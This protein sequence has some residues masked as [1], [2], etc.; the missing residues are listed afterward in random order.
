MPATRPWDWP[1]VN[2]E[3]ITLGTIWSNQPGVRVFVE[4]FSRG[5][6]IIFQF[7]YNR[8]QPQG[9]PSRLVNFYHKKPVATATETYVGYDEMGKVVWEVLS[10]VWNS[11]SKHMCIRMPDVMVEIFEDPDRELQ[12]YLFH[13][14]LYELYLEE[15]L[16]LHLVLTWAVAHEAI[17]TYST[18]DLI[19]HG[20]FNSQCD[21]QLVSL[22]LNPDSLFI[23]KGL[24]C[25]KRMLAGPDFRHKIKA[26]YDEIRTIRSLHPHSNIIIPHTIFVMGAEISIEPRQPLVCGTLTPYMKNG[27]LNDEI[28]R[29]VDADTRL[30]VKENAKWCFQ[31]ISAINH[32]HH[33]S[34]SYHMNIKSSNFLINDQ[35]NL[36]L[37]DWEQNKA[38]QLTLA[39]EAD[40]S[41]DVEVQ[42]QDTHVKPIYRKYPGPSR[43]N[44]PFSWP[45]WNVFPIWRHVCPR[46]LEA[47]EVYSLG[48]TM[49]MLLAQVHEELSLDYEKMNASERKFANEENYLEWSRV[50]RECMDTD[51]NKRPD[52][53]SLQDFWWKEYAKMPSKR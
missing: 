45:R 36:I 8:D 39:P 4:A 41:Y 5:L 50:V 17:W 9:I 20:Y 24:D 28:R 49:W 52:M 32:T 43:V 31:M 23:F 16:P 19:Y 48:R 10:R 15:L 42:Q 30:D 38:S 34:H 51:A 13:N 14:T 11:C 46:A 12:W 40:G 21:K 26:C 6:R 47:A 25:S 53:Q 33:V 2:L 27:N 7:T 22:Q 37:I 29:A 35:R 1:S 3:S 18:A 44:N